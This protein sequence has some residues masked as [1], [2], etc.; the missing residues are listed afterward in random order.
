MFLVSPLLNFSCYYL[1]ISAVEILSFPYL[2]RLVEFAS[3]SGNDITTGCSLQS[4]FSLT[5]ET[6]TAG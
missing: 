1:S 6:H 5:T 2:V 4:H 3:L